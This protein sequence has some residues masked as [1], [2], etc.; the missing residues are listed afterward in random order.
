MIT[1]SNE[2]YKI[3]YKI[4]VDQ[5]YSRLYELDELSKKALFVDSLLKKY[6]VTQFAIALKLT[7]YNIEEYEISEE[8]KKDILSIINEIEIP[9]N[10]LDSFKKEVEFLNIFK[11]YFSPLLYE[12]LLD[13]SIK[14]EIIKEVEYEDNQKCLILKLQFSD[15]NSSIIHVHRARRGLL[16]Y[17]GNFFIIRNSLSQQII[18]DMPLIKV[19]K[20]NDCGQ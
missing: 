4:A 8:P 20:I 5:V 1:I 14:A 18:K 7:K 16:Y 19:G 3:G 2:D 9:E 6:S 12:Y 13:N 10:L 17:N 11:N 15:Y